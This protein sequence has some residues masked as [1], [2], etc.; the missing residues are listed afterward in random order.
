VTLGDVT[1]KELLAAG[2]VERIG[3]FGLFRDQDTAAITTECG[4]VVA[5][6]PAVELDP[7]KA[8]VVVA[9]I[10]SAAQAAI[11]ASPAPP[12]SLMAERRLMARSSSLLGSSRCSSES[13]V[14]GIVFGSMV[15]IIGPFASICLGVT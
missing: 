5:A 11:N 8:A 12:S 9:P 2:E 6:V 15:V 3:A 7:D 1:P 10:G 13:G 4:G 14:V